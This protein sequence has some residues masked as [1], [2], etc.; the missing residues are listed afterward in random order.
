[1]PVPATGSDW[2]EHG[3]YMLVGNPDVFFGRDGAVYRVDGTDTAR[4]MPPVSL[5]RLRAEAVSGLSP[6]CRPD[7]AGEFRSSPCWRLDR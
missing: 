2:L 1:M 3:P 4:L 5:A 7:R 6:S